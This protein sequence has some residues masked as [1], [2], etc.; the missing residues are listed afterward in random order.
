[1]KFFNPELQQHFER[2]LPMTTSLPEEQR[3]IC[4]LMDAYSRFRL[5]HGEYSDVVR[6]TLDSLLLPE[7]RSGLR[8]WYRG[9]D[10]MNPFARE[11]RDRLSQMA[12]ET[13]G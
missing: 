1:V 3:P 8:S 13:F 12:E 10:N 4:A 5:T 6:E 2:V 9:K 11:F 7:S